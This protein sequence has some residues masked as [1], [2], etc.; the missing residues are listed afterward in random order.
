MSLLVLYVFHIEQI[1][2]TLNR[3]SKVIFYIYVEI[4]LTSI[5]SHLKIF[6]TVINE[7]TETLI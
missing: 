6:Q 7:I 3:Q 1:T 4:Y 2:V 5:E